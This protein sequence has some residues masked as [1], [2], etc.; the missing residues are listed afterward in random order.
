M[1]V[2]AAIVVYFLFLD[3]LQQNPWM[4][5]AESLG[6]AEPR[7][8]STEVGLGLVVRYSDMCYL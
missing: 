4:P 8:K 5:L 1:R 3:S 6:S 7:L 2:V